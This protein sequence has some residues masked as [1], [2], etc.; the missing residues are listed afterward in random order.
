MAPAREPPMARP[1][2]HVSATAPIPSSATNA[3]T[4]TGS[5]FEIAADGA[6]RK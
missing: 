5:A 3:V 6:R 4:T 2:H 1:S